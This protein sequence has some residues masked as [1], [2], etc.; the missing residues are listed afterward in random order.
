VN[1]I[2]AGY[3]Y[4][5]LVS[6]PETIYATGLGMI[7]LSGTASAVMAV[8][9]N[10]NPPALLAETGA[11]PVATG[12]NQLGLTSITQLSTGRYWVAVDLDNEISVCANTTSNM[13]RY[14]ALSFGTTPPK[15]LKGATSTTAV[16]YNFYVVGHQ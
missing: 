9:S 1:S 13:T 2:P 16:N 6:V 4:A 12:D 7:G 15:S 8:Y 10:E 3:L 11:G 5:E 14:M